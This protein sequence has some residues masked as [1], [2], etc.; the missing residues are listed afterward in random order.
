MTTVETYHL[1]DTDTRETVATGYT[2]AEVLAE[3]P[4]MPSDCVEGAETWQ[5][6]IEAAACHADGIA[7]LV[8]GYT[9]ERIEY[10][11]WYIA[12]DTQTTAIYGIGDSP[13]AAAADANRQ[14]PQDEPREWVTWAADYKLIECVKRDGGS[15]ISWSLRDGIATLDAD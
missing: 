12:T 14:A 3:T 8:E 1:I 6:V 15:R 4:Y 5:Q 7:G 10:A 11:R 2:M 13:E 9:V